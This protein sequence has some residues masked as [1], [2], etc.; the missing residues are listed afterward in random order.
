[1]ST[2][3]RIRSHEGLLWQVDHVPLSNHRSGRS[4]PAGAVHGKLGRVLFPTLLLALAL[5]GCS[6]AGVTAPPP[7]ERDF[8]I[9][10]KGHVATPSTL[11]AYEGDTLKI[12]VVV[13]RKERIHLSG[14]DKSFAASPGK[15]VTLTF[16]ADR[17]G[18]FEYAIEATSQHLGILNVQPR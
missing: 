12:T 13:D 5:A 17:T 16:K 14:Y 15:P 10:V 8:M 7:Q 9:T 3:E 6:P 4:R 1:M 18:G 2:S 11:N